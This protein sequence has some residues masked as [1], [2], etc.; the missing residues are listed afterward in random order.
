VAR[1]GAWLIAAAA[2]VAL[3]APAL[4]PHASNEQF[5]DRAYAPPTRLHIFDADGLHA[6]FIR[7]LV[8][9][10]RLARRYR[11]E[12][13][14][15]VSLRWFSHGRFVSSADPRE[16]LLLLGAD[17]LGRDVFS[18]LVAGAR[19]SLGVTFLGVLGAS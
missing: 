11:H 6:P 1:A 10:D 12:T 16:P 8:L 4:A 13:S 7:P 17:A 3:A 19:L 14:A 15:R 18:R 2:F 9:E 5:A